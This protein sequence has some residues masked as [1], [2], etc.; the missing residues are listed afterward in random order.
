MIPFIQRLFR[1]DQKKIKRPEQ[2]KELIRH[3]TSLLNGCAFCQ[4]TSQMRGEKANIPLEKFRDLLKFEDSKAFDPDEKVMLSYVRE[5]VEQKKVSEDTY[6]KLSEHFSEEGIIEITWIAST[7]VYM[8]LMN[9]AFDIR[10]DGFCEKA[11]RG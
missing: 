2:E 7:E 5:L 10:S 9:Q 8:N 1:I 6:S 4:D 3:F 11:R